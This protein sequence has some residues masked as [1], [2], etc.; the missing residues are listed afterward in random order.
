LTFT[1]AHG[2]V[3]YMATA[4]NLQVRQLFRD[5]RQ[6]DAAGVDLVVTDFEPVAARIARRRGIPSIG[7]ANQ[8]AFFH[9]IPM[10]RWN[11]IDKWVLKHFAPGGRALGMQW[12]HFDQPILPPILPADLVPDRAPVPG[13]VVVYFPFEDAGA[14]ARLFGPVTEREFFIYGLEKEARDEGHLHYRGFSRAGFLGDMFEAEGVVCNAGFALCSEALYLGKKLLA[15]PVH[16]QLEQTTNVRILKELGLGWGMNKLDVN[17]LR[18]WLET[19]PPPPQRWPDVAG[20]VAKWIDG[21]KW[22]DT[23]GLVRECWV[24]K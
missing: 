17:V 14:V 11:P 3:Q 10:G 13:K 23:E 21:G 18:K 5:V 15:K 22:E 2:R 19:A 12:H 1:I 24:G 6:F 8:Y 7:L 16:L 9:R 4:F 20:L